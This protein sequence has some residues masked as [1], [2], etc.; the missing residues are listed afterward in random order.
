MGKTIPYFLLHF[1]ISLP[2]IVAVAQQMNNQCQFH[3][4]IHRSGSYYYILVTA[5]IAYHKYH[6]VC[7]GGY[8][9]QY[10]YKVTAVHIE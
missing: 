3:H 8:I 2:G 6:C 4:Y 1:H 9:S 5:C 10:R 7:H